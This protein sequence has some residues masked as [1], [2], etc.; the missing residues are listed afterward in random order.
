MNL[1]HQLRRQDSN[2]TLI[3]PDSPDTKCRICLCGVFDEEIERYCLCE[4]NIGIV[5]KECLLKWINTSNRL[6]CEI[7]NHNYNLKS[8]YKPNYN[9]ILIMLAFIG[10]L[11]LFVLMYIE[12]TYKQTMFLFGTFTVLFLFGTLNA[13]CKNSFFITKTFILLP[14]KFV[15]SND[16]NEGIKDNED[17]NEDNEDNNE[18]TNE[19]NE[20]INEDNSNT[21][22][23]EISLV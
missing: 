4:G 15:E 17:T 14:Y 11:A 19:Y 16:N 12:K 10:W 22:E 3:P 2:T 8:K 5:H 9:M 20:D 6:K 13:G 1:S 18:D 23:D 7:C 21:Y